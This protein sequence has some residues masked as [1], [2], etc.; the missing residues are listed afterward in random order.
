MLEV[1]SAV[2]GESV[3]VFE[4]V[5]SADVAVK[6]LKQR[7]WRRSLASHASDYG[8]FKTTAHCM[9]I[10]PWST[11][12]PWPFKL[13]SLWSWSF[14]RLTGSKIGASWSMWGQW[15][16]TSWAKIEHTTK[17]EFSKCKSNHTPVCGSLER[18]SQMCT[19]TAW[20][21]CQQ[22][23][24]QHWLILDQHSKETLI[25]YQCCLGLSSWERAPWSCPIAAG[26]RC[27]QRPRPDRHW[28]NSATPLFIAAQEGQLEVVRFL[29]QSGANKDQGTTD[30]V[31]ATPLF[32]AAQEGDLEVV[33][34]LVEAGANKDHGRTDDEATPF[35]I[36]A[37]NGQFEIDRFLVVRDNNK[38][39]GGKKSLAGTAWLKWCIYTRPFLID[40]L[41][42]FAKFCPSVSQ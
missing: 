16:Q 30:A 25:Q 22:R 35:Y 37:Q 17:C 14:C 28:S 20:S 23:P 27:Q 38:V 8:S 13:Y 1:L 7:A 42:L 24:R 36:A 18:K 15:R 26:V 5:D 4:K 41:I 9:T 33:R 10:K 39:F 12:R 34:F 29:V 2:T 40:M 6:T 19:S 32:I 21:W 31:G 11:I 3:V